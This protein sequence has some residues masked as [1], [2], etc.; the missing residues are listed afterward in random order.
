MTLHSHDGFVRF[1]AGLPATTT[2]AQWGSLVAKVGGKVFCLLGD[3]EGAIAF[4]V[5]EIAYAGLVDL[6]GIA[7]AP[8]FAKGQW[9]LVNPG[10][11]EE[12]LLAGYLTEAHRL[13]AGK[14]T[15]KARAELG[16]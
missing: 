15:R 12:V 5:T 11:L 7:Q 4:K 8:Y 13:I 9:V 14:L 2:V 10:A 16:L 6:P 1:I 3:T